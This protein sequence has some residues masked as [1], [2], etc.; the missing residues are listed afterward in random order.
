MDEWV[1]DN[2]YSI[3][4]CDL[5]SISTIFTKCEMWLYKH[6]VPAIVHF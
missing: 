4:L 3:F 6:G 2:A 5:E 1:N